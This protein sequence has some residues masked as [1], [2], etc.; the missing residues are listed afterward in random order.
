[1]KLI[2][3]INNYTEEEESIRFKKSNDF[4]S[5]N[6][7]MDFLLK[8]EVTNPNMTKSYVKTYQE[9]FINTN[10]SIEEI[11]ETFI[12]HTLKMIHDME[13]DA[14]IENSKEID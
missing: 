11:K 13:E 8:M 3:A 2:T 7:Y 9:N 1:M 14:R 6:D 4:N 12:V 5:L 10:L